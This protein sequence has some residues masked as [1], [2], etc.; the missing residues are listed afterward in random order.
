MWEEEHID[1]IASLECHR[2]AGKRFA[3]TL[4][5]AKGGG[6]RRDSPNSF[7]YNIAPITSF[8]SAGNA[9]FQFTLLQRISI[10]ISLCS[11]LASLHCAPSKMHTYIFYHL[12]RYTNVI[13]N[14]N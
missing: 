1:S 8:A 11:T 10:R 14:Y 12:R 6:I 3:Q 4:S 13:R 2:Q 9:L 5:Q 7:A